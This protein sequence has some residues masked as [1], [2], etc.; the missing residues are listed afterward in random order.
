MPFSFIGRTRS[1]TRPRDRPTPSYLPPPLAPVTSLEL[2]DSWR[3]RFPIRPVPA[4]RSATRASRSSPPPGRPSV[5]ARA[6]DAIVGV[7]YFSQTS[8]ED[9]GRFDSAFVALFKVTAGGVWTQSLAA[10]GPDGSV[11]FGPTL[12]L[13][14]YIMVVNWTLLPVSMAVLVDS[15]VVVSANAAREDRER[16]IF[17]AKDSQLIKYTLD[18]LLRH[19]TTH[20]I[21]DSDLTDRLQ[22]L[23]QA[24]PP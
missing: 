16:R 2:R 17:L 1:R 22:R 9:F 20:Y 24:R 23:F 13:T 6:A 21:D 18:P 7:T 19:L 8:P 3:S 11:V 4:A 15:F 14:T 5:R 10:R 12:F